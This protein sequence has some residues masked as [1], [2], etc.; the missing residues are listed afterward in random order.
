MKT[1]Y[2]WTTQISNEDES[3]SRYTESAVLPKI[4]DNVPYTKLDISSLAIPSYVKLTDSNFHMPAQLNAL[5]GNELSFEILKKDQI[6]L[7]NGKFIL[8]SQFM[9]A[10][11]LP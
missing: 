9:L 6:H 3:F 8:Q 11:T 2:T 7:T 1:K 4:A 5:I 10:V